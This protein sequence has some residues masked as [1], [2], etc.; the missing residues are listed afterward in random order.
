LAKWRKFDMNQDKAD[1]E[2]NKTID[3]L[4]G[5][6]DK[7]YE[8]RGLG[9][10]V[11][12]KTLKAGVLA[13]EPTRITVAGNIHADELARGWKIVAKARR[14]PSWHPRAT[15]AKAK[16]SR[17]SHTPLSKPEIQTMR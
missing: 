6:R 4:F 15:M 14:Q 9:I 1:E 13:K 16:R 7:A 2:R 5:V 12:A 17:W 10:D 8:K 11:V 3:E